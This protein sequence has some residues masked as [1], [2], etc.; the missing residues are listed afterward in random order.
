MNLYKSILF[1]TCCFPFVLQ[2]HPGDK[3]KKTKKINKTYT[4][5]QNVTVDI[6]NSFGD[7][8]IELWDQSSV[9]ID[10]VVKVSG[11]NEDRVNE[12]LERI[13]VDFKATNRT[14]KAVSDIPNEST[15]I[16]GWIKGDTGTDT[17]V[18]MIV[19]MPVNATL[20]IENDY[21]A[22]IIPK[23]NAPLKLSCDFGRL[24]LGQLLN[25]YNELS[26]DYTE[27]SSID[28][29]KGGTI[30]ADFSKFK[31]YG[32]DVIDFT[33][34]YTTAA[35][36]PVKNFK[37]NSDFS[38]LTID[39]AQRIDARGDYSTVSI[40]KLSGPAIIKADFGSLT[41][42]ELASDFSQLSIKSDYTTINIGYAPTTSFNYLIETEFGSLKLDSSL[43][44]RV[45]RND[46][47]EKYREGHHG[48]INTTNAIEINSSFG[49][50]KL[51]NNNF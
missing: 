22:I 43:K 8:T 10:V 31:V 16:M 35:F 30:K 5:D 9:S 7:V 28:Y 26:F 21:G 51:N 33:G 49:T 18:N 6:I 11:N 46:M 19:K 29:L 1:L 2:A 44:T 20:E 23:M 12:R 50:I 48:N 14:V 41:I 42:A 13:D 38:T 40:G 4:V 39:G 24:Q 15:G 45:S 37:Y 3:F 25:P 27:N 17:Q 34:D 47:N 36:A 32:A